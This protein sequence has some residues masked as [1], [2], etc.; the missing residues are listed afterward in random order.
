MNSH[1]KSLTH[2][3]LKCVQINKTFWDGY[4]I[5]Q[6]FL[7]YDKYETY[8]E[9]EKFINRII[10]KL[11]FSEDE[12]LIKVA[13]NYRKWK[14][15]IINGLERNQTGKRFSNFVA[16]NTNSHIDKVINASYGYRN[17]K[18][19][20]AGVMLILTYNNKRGRIG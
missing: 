4:N 15:G 6:E 1:K 3:I 20:R 11:V 19:F 2:I 18:R 8:G 12:M 5:L 16:E 10:S 9:A 14:V 17:F 13:E 7:H